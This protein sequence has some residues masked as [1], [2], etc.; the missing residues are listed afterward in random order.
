MNPLTLGQKAAALGI[1]AL[2]LAAASFGA[3]WQVRTWKANSDELKAV[4]AADKKRIEAEARLDAQAL[5]FENE[6]VALAQRG[7]DIRSTI[8]EI[9]RDV[10]SPPASC[11]APDA[12]RRLLIDAGARGASYDPGQPQGGVPGSP[13]AAEPAARP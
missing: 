13:A 1:G 2:L 10:P 8:R 6:R 7:A 11:A 3:G 4:A 5:T 12:A 9:Y